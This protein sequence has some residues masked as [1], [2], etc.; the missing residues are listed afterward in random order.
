MAVVGYVEDVWF[1]EYLGGDEFKYA[2]FSNEVPEPNLF[3]E[4]FEFIWHSTL[5]DLTQ[6]CSCAE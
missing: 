3:A 1:A 4:R 2:R 6:Q 5:L